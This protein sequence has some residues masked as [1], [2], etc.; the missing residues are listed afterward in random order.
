MCRSFI[1]STIDSASTLDIGSSVWGDGTPLPPVLN[2]LDHSKFDAA[3]VSQPLQLTRAESVLPNEVRFTP[4]EATDGVS[5]LAI[6]AIRY[7]Q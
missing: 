4:F 3:A 1:C 2:L 6:G 7:F 5:Q